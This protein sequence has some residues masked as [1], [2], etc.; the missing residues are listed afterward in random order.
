MLRSS[1]PATKK[2]M[3][4]PT[5]SFMG[6]TSSLSAKRSRREAASRQP[7]GGRGWSSGKDLLSCCHSPIKLWLVENQGKHFSTLSLSHLACF[8]FKSFSA[9]RHLGELRHLSPSWEP[10]CEHDSLLADLHLLHSFHDLMMDIYSEE[11]RRF[12]KCNKLFS[13]LLPDLLLQCFTCR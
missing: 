3:V 4:T 7:L 9:P 10:V 13:N 12:H 6:R 2:V 11:L 5:T 1:T 8:S